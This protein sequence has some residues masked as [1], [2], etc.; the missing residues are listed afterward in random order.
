[1]VPTLG[2]SLPKV[3]DKIANPF[4]LDNLPW[5]VAIPK[6]VY[7]LACSTLSNPSRAANST[8][9]TLTSF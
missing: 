9:L 7:L 6:V 2:I 8:S 5:S 1:M 3:D 4:M